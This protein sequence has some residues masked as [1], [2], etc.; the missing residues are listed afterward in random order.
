MYIFL[1]VIHI[2]VCSVLIVTILLQAGKGAGLNEMFG[3]DASQSVLGTQAPVL[4]KKAT[5]VSAVA[6]LVTSLVLGMVTARRGRSLF[7]R[8][9]IPAPTA[10]ATATAPRGP[11]SPAQAPA[12][13]GEG[14]VVTPAKKDTTPIGKDLAEPKNK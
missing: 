13:P 10:T 6:F 1:I 5:T 3:G 4:I 9:N 7:D 2:I 12:V 14:N 8:S 11:F